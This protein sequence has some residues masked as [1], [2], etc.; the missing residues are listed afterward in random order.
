MLAVGGGTRQ[1]DGCVC[2]ASLHSRDPN[3]KLVNN[4]K[5][6]SKNAVQVRKAKTQLRP[7]T[8]NDALEKSGNYRHRRT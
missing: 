8:L 5:S 7:T 6:A 3:M 4:F 1:E 2:K